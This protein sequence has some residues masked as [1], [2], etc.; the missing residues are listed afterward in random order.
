MQKTQEELEQSRERREADAPPGSESYPEIESHFESPSGMEIDPED[1]RPRPWVLPERRRVLL[2]IAILLTLLLIAVLPPLISANRFRRRIAQS[3]SESLGRPVHMRDVNFTLLPMPGFTL[4]DFE[5]ADDPAF[6][7]E[8]VMQARTVRVTLRVWSLWR[9]RV[10]FSRITLD[11]PSVNLVHRADGH[12]N[13]ES[14]LLQAAKIEAAPTAQAGVGAAPRFPYIEATGARVNVTM[15]LEKMPLALTDADLALWLPE[16]S[17]WRLRLEGHPTRTDTAP[18]DTGTLRIQGT[19]GKAARIE[20]VP[21]DVTAEWATAPLG[22]AS[23]VVLGRD[24]GLRGDL[25]LS[26]SVRG[27]IGQ[28]VVVTRLAVSDLR[29]A[30]FVPRRSLALNL[31]CAAQAG[32]LFHRLTDLHCGSPAEAIADQK[33]AGIT[34]AS[35]EVVLNSSSMTFDAEIRDVNAEGLLDTLRVGSARVSPELSL[36]GLISGRLECCATDQPPLEAWKTA[37]GAVTIP[38]AT[39]ALG[40]GKA[41]LNGP[42]G[43]QI[44]SGAVNVEPI[45]LELD[46]LQ[47]AVLEGRADSNGYTLHLSGAVLRSRLLQLAG[48]LPQFGDGLTE[49]LPPAPAAGVAEA[50]MRVDLVSNRSW[51]GGQTWTAVPVKATKGR[52][53]GRRR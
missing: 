1:L 49:A 8:P 39:L 14:I 20:D 52:R 32:E 10:E 17:E 33:V 28:N 23:Y 40:D 50:P 15:G 25:T 46:G 7:M 6:G 43:A 44:G 53:T 12:W 29:R 5:V 19:L 31:T 13:I 35:P 2:A 30:D 18:T 42:V 24:A 26:G 48:A 3:V 11:D 45:A 4:T 34:A 51:K 22:G 37:T 27:T 16:P 9:R 47:P 21:V 38:V 41:F 36:G